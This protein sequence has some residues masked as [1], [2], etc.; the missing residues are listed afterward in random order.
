[1]GRSLCIWDE[2]CRSSLGFVLTEA[3]VQSFWCATVAPASDAA[4]QGRGT[5]T[6]KQRKPGPTCSG[7]HVLVLE[8][9]HHDRDVQQPR[10]IRQAAR[11]EVRMRQAL[12]RQHDGLAARHELE[13]WL[14]HQ[15]IL[16]GGLHVH[17]AG[18][19]RGLEGRRDV[20]G[21]PPNVEVRLAAPQDAADGLAP[22]DP[23]AHGQ[24]VAQQRG[25]AL[26]RHLRPRGAAA[27]AQR[28][29]GDAAQVRMGHP[30]LHSDPCASFERGGG[31]EGG[32]FGPKTWCTKNGRTRYSLS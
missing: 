7:A 27:A 5:G 21:R 23:E 14:V 30:V 4:G 13:L 28:T 6:G 12:P 22:V 10:G 9:V 1:M 20:D 3:R 11:H 24:V 29:G 26:R 16:Q 8:V 2:L 32:V 17:F 19:A 31:R 25:R 15:Q 18:E